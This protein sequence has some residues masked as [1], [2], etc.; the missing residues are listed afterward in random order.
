[1]GRLLNKIDSPRDLKKL[2]V[3]ELSILAEELRQII[4]STVASN[5]GHLA[6]SLGV[7][8]LTIVMHYL[9]NT[10]EDKIIWDVGHQSY[11]HKLLTG[12]RR[13]FHT[14]R[15][16]RGL[17]G[18]PKRSESEYDA[19][20]VGHSSTAISA[21]LGIAAARDLEGKSFHVIAVVGDGALTGGL[22]YEG[23]NNAGA[24]GKDIIVILNDNSMSI[25]P[26]VGAMSKYLTGIIA[27]PLYNRIKNE[28]WE[29][30]G[31][32]SSAG[33][34][35]R[36]AARKI[37]ESLK[38]FI[39]P[40]VLF[41]RL[42]FRYFGP[43]DGHNITELIE[44]LNETKRLKGPLLFHILTKKGKGYEPA[45][46]NAPYFHG[47]G[48][49]DPRTGHALKKTNVPSYTDVFEQT[50]VELAYQNST[51][52]AITAAMQIGAG[53]TLF[54]KTFPN[55]F[56]D[57]G[58]AEGHAVTFAAGLASQGMRPVCAIYSSFL[59]R[60]YDM[61]IHD[62]ALQQLPVILAI[63]RA[64]LVGDDGPTHH[65]IYDM[66]FLRT[67]PNMVIMAPKDEQ[68]LR[69]MLSA[70]VAYDSGPIAIRYPRALGEGVDTPGN[71]NAVPISKSEL[72]IEGEDIAIIAVG[73]LVY[74]ALAAASV[75]L[76]E[77]GLNVTIINARFVKPVDELMLKTTALRHSLIVTVE[78]GTIKGGFGSEV[79]EFITM[80]NFQHVEL[81]RLGIPDTFIEQ[82]ERMFL[83]STLNLSAEGIVQKIRSSK[84]Y[85]V[86]A[87][88]TLSINR[89]H[90]KAS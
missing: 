11:A 13:L 51:I 45:E 30:T 87:P 37:E 62:V 80:H 77:D 86:L 68:E 14:I 15:Q 34:V 49:F 66:A 56:Y 20:G 82:G 5:G 22:A 57:V 81:I 6:P 23:L 39:T 31:R 26:N 53:L 55:R 21:A 50:I 90:S 9:F 27:H 28:I 75:L 69:E 44:L 8:E 12:R 88:H 7:V 89:Q 63:D 70:A 60:A 71:I 29:I 67:I 1:M 19:F 61:L 36:K 16:Y 78:E 47:L 72:L 42:G 46:K 64:G 2:T 54:S 18:F 40:G 43:I 52:C 3:D 74:Q 58:I 65:G 73:P 25:S 17:S 79:A 33:P 4:V 32:M 35:I 48:K 83:L 76:A 38:A 59:Q 10:P 41:E 24:A 85:P 84:S